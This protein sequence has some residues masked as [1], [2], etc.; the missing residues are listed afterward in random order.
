MNKLVC[1]DLR[2]CEQRLVSKIRS[3]IQAEAPAA[4]VSHLPILFPPKLVDYV[5]V[6]LDPVCA[7]SAGISDQSER[8]FIHDWRGF[9][10]HDCLKKQRKSYYISSLSKA[11]IS[12]PDQ[13][14]WRETYY[15]DWLDAFRAEMDALLAPEGVIIPLGSKTAKYLQQ[16]A[17]PWPLSAALTH[18]SS[19]AAHW[20]QRLPQQYPLEYQTFKARLNST[21]MVRS[22]D[23]TLMTLFQVEKSIFETEIPYDF[24]RLRLEALEGDLTVLTESQQQLMF[25]YFKQ[26]EQINYS[27][28][29]A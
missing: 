27:I 1:T 14:K 18:F 6:S 9:F 19:Q 11:V 5:V 24:M 12:A 25:T 16:Q 3:E 4:R 23:H 20:H 8:H 22:A 17:L 28:I 29:K 26:M 2:Q 15:A 13:K 7:A 21:Q 10:L